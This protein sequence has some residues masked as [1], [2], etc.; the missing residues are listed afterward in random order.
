MLAIGQDIKERVVKHVVYRD[1]PVEIVA[2]KVKD[3]TIHPKRK[4]AGNSDWLNGMTVTL[5]NVS[6]R[7][8]AYVSVLVGAPFE[9]NGE[10]ISAGVDLQYGATPL[11]PGE[12]APVSTSAR[13]P[14]PPGET[15]DV[16]LSEEKRDEL[17]SLLQE[18]NASTDI[19][20][21]SIRVYDVFFEGDSEMRWRGGRIYRRD[22]NDPWYWIPIMPGTSSN[23]TS[24]K[25]R[26]VPAWLAAPAR[27]FLLPDPS[28]ENC[29]YRDGGFSKVELC[30]A[31]NSKGRLC[32]WDNYQLYNTGTFNTLPES[33]TKYCQGG[34]EGAVCLKSEAHADSISSPQDCNPAGSPIIIDITGNGIDLTNIAGGVRFDL[35]SNGVPE[36]LSWT[37]VGSD[38]AW[39]ALDRDGNGTIDGGKELFGNFTPQSATWNPQGFLALAEYDKQA[40]SGNNDGVIDSRDAVFASL[41]LW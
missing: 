30:A 9:K 35:N 1:Q 27:A 33:F 22:P 34:E 4:F 37:A 26:F 41:R 6:E 20:E 40:N 32:I 19:T 5:K 10:R 8:V 3:A 39:L 18:N 17:Y 29:K 24:S 38:D 2:V 12:V 13:R 14:L 11:L 28:I 31:Y 36:S 25:P 16:V 7:P 23:R 21:L 15:A